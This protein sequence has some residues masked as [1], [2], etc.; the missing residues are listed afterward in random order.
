LAIVVGMLIVVTV[1]GAASTA[2]VMRTIPVGL[3]PGGVSS[4]GTHVWV[5]DSGPG[6]TV[7]H[8]VCEIGVS[9]GRV[10][11]TIGVG[12]VPS[13]VSSDG[14]DVWVANAGPDAKPGHKVT[15]IR[16]TP[17]RPRVVGH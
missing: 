13:A 2:R 15:E 16:R 6:L 7:G 5:A 10:I 11:R 1:S 4:D 9:S 3:G 8:T 12:T 14:R 17:P